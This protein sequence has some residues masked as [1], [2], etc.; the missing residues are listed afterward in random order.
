MGFLILT[1][2]FTEFTRY[3]NLQ[4]IFT[5]FLSRNLENTQLQKEIFYNQTFE[6]CKNT[7]KEFI[8]LDFGREI[9]QNKL[10]IKCN[11]I[12]YN[13][14][15]QL[16]NILGKTFLD[17][18]YFQDYDCSSISC[19]WTLAGNE[20]FKFTF[21][22]QANKILSSYIIVFI[23]GTIFGIALIY[24]GTRNILVTIKSIGFNFVLGGMSYF[25]LALGKPII[26]SIIPVG[27]LA[28]VKPIIDNFIQIISQKFLFIF[29]VGMI[30][31]VLH[32]I[33]KFL[34]TRKR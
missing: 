25:V 2:T 3:E 6:E 12:V 21:S 13:N 16:D 7:G 17:A 33:I 9:L 34:K 23:G 5:N 8:E 22:N 32:Y 24:L 14:F 31:V 27:Q 18:I 1:L 10:K 26:T 20:L 19:F 28:V 11:D 15:S 30:L 4:P 29:I